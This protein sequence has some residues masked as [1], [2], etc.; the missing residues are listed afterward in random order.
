MNFVYIPVPEEH[1]TQVHALLVKLADGGS[2]DGNAAAGGGGELAFGGW[3]EEEL[4]R[5]STSPQ[6]S[7]QRVAR[8][9]DL[10]SQSPGQ[11]IAYTAIAASL[12]LTRG[13][14]QGA[15][16][17]F[18]RWIRKNWGN[19]D[20]WPMDVTY[21]GAQTQ[22]QASESYYIVTATTANRWLAVRSRGSLT[23]SDPM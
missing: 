20:G 14:L 3:T 12:R 19:E 16:S 13:E 6:E 8:M 15:L 7:V 23:D 18:S 22:G 17:G 5:L 9:L 4:G 1:A 2:N 21:R 11:P 10:L